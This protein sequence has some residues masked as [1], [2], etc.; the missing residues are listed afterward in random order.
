M[1]QRNYTPAIVI[2]SIAINTIIAIMYFMPKNNDF[3]HLDLTFLPFL[4]A[5]M[6]SFTFVFLIAALVSIIKYKNIQ[7]HRR[8][9]FAAFCTTAVFLISY[10]VYHGMAP[11]TSYGGEGIL[12][13]I[14]YFILL[15]HILLSAVIVPFALITTA[16]GLN[17]QV[18]RHKK[19]A[20]WTMPMWLYVS[21]TGVIVYLMISPYY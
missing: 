21:A 18:D 12:R 6:N 15:S 19:I 10:L 2:L 3:G 14:Y 9:I 13:P 4:N 1:K 17:M 11:S 16:R 5:V 8:Y 7:L 20:R